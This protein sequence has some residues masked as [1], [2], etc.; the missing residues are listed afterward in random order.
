MLFRAVAVC[1]IVSAL[2]LPVAHGAPTDDTLAARRAAWLGARRA[3]QAGRHAEAL[4]A[5]ARLGD[6]PL[7]P[8]VVYE[9]LRRRLPALPA[10]AIAE[11]LAREDGSFLAAR[12][13][14]E[15]LQEL[16]RRQQ[17]ALYHRDWRQQDDL[18]LRCHAL[19]AALAEGAR[20][21]ALVQ[22]TELWLLGEPM[23][24]S[25]DAGF[26]ALTA[27]PR[28]DD[29]LVWA[30]LQ[31]AYARGH[32]RLG[33]WLARQLRAPEA[34]A[35]GELWARAASDPAA[36]IGTLMNAGPATREILVWA[37]ERYA[38]RN[39]DAARAAWQQALA[40]QMLS[41]DASGR[42]AAA[43]ARRAADTAHPARMALL[44]AVPPA[45]V[46]DVTARY[47]LR[48]AIA[49]NDWDAL[50]RWTALTPAAADEALRFRY[51][52]ARA[53][54]HHGDNKAAQ[55]ALQSLA[56]E[57]DYYGFLAA[58]ALGLDYAFNPRDV[59]ADP[60]ETAALLARPGLQ[61][62]RELDHLRLTFEARREWYFELAQ[63]APR[64]LEVA[65]T[66][67]AQWGWPDA[68]I[69]ALGQAR[70]WDDLTLRFPLLHQDIAVDQA[71]RRQLDPARVLAIIRSESAFAR[72]ARS[73]AGAL[74]LMQLLPGTARET[75]RRIGLGYAGNAQLFEPRSNI[76]LGT[77]YLA[78]VMAQ[79]G[80][81]F[82]MAAAAYNAGPGRVRQWQGQACVAAERWI[83]M[84]PFAE[85]KA[86]VR[87]ALFYT[88]I[89][90][91]R[92]G[93]EVTRLT[94]SMGAIPPRG[95]SRATGCT[96]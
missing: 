88:A 92:L 42:I 44:D 55:A 93:H 1:L 48:E 5:A 64:E 60:G 7:A 51:W 54:L 74:G 39:V 26:A 63:M 27:S 94:A 32:T 3:Q 82:V 22:A 19:T 86:Y 33:A 45:A 46:D 6:Y 67:A 2:A 25:C 95:A 37:L 24:A 31:K 17:W 38:A 70:S 61:R 53:L 57:R 73:G 58:D 62:A 72:E 75:A 78:Q 4:G 29:A 50:L 14:R 18:E 28:F 56:R 84:I 12:L 76:T 23:P 20:E 36:A 59:G 8:Y 15:W 34:R 66:I 91:W 81:S 9:D 79:Y 68:A 47:R 52:Q 13:R 83:E 96:S 80:G 65:A 10:R 49:R 85:T 71:R 40:R 77:A 90:Q 87:R 43:L 89:Y 35:R 11:F 30:R 16:A 21:Q 41:P 69:A